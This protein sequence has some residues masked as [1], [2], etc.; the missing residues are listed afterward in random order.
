MQARSFSAMIKI[1]RP[2][3]CCWPQCSAGELRCSDMLSSKSTSVGIGRTYPSFLLLEEIRS[4]TIN[5]SI[6]PKRCDIEKRA[7]LSSDCDADTSF[8]DFFYEK[9]RQTINYR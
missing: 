7:T 4:A 6:S 1:G 2:R 9:R 5:Q 8:I 3:V